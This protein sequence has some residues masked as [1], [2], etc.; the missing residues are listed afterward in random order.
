MFF[1]EIKMKHEARKAG[2]FSGL[3]IRSGNIRNNLNFRV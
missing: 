1:A 2:R 3:A